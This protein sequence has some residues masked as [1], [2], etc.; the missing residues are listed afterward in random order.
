MLLNFHEIYPERLIFDRLKDSNTNLESTQAFRNWK[1]LTE[2]F[3]SV[4]V[5]D[6]SNIFNPSDFIR[7]TIE[8]VFNWM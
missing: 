2:F 6:L 4:V 8:K 1:L 3:G 5:H 7:K